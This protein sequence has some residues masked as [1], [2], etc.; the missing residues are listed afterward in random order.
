MKWV[1]TGENLHLEILID[2]KWKHYKNTPFVTTEGFIS[3][4]N[5]FATAQK[6]LKNGYKYMRVLHKDDFV[7][8][9]LFY[10]EALKYFRE[11]LPVELD[12][13]GFDEEGVRKLEKSIRLLVDI[14][15]EQKVRLLL[16]LKNDN[17]IFRDII[18]TFIET[19]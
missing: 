15:G 8:Y 3:S 9:D 5:G 7:D 4:N 13:S 17:P 14:F 10:Q 1:R 19:K 18:S 6:A 2:G 11:E 12:L 16:S